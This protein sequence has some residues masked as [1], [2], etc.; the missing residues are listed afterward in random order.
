MKATT[1]K[2]EARRQALLESAYE[3]FIEQGFAKT[4]L[5]QI[6]S[7]AGG[8]KR[9]VYQ[10]FGD[11]QGLF[12]AVMQHHLNKGFVDVLAS[13]DDCDDHVPETLKHIGHCFIT[14]LLSEQALALYRVLVAE[15]KQCPSLG[16]RFYEIGPDKVN[17]YLSG[18][19]A[20]QVSHGM[21]S[22]SDV[23]TAAVSFLGM[24]KGDLQMAALLNP[25]RLPCSAVIEA[26]VDWAVVCFLKACNYPLE[27]DRNN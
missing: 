25:K 21:L 17:Q 7:H 23:K 5:D 3:L 11:K 26:R 9:N 24:V 16:E 6:I 8:S 10:Y 22:I 19:L 18:Y 27:I 14:L 20:H 1:Q 12:V 4:S 13:L 2:G 15:V